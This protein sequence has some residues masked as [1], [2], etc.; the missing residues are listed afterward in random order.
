MTDLLAHA[1]AAL[2]ASTTAPDDAVSAL[3][4]AAARAALSKLEEEL[5]G[6]EIVVSAREHEL[7]RRGAPK[8][9][10]ALETSP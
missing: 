5:R 4:V 9:Q 2:A 10:L 3:Y 6:L 8:E 1:H 7:A